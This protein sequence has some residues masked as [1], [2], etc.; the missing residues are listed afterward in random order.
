MRPTKDGEILS[1][2][3]QEEKLRK[4]LEE[5][6]TE[7]DPTSETDTP[8]SGTQEWD[9][10]PLVLPVSLACFVVVENIQ[11]FYW[12]GSTRKKKKKQNTHTHRRK[13]TE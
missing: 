6:D 12:V 2:E 5:S 9:T 10:R 1:S 7:D 3:E 11:L 8:T 13:K 4:M